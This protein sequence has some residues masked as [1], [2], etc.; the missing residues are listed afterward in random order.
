ML[1]GSNIMVSEKVVAKI[2]KKK[3]W[4]LTNHNDFQTEVS[5][6]NSIK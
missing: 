6:L 5:F 2:G 4:K 3:Y 1:N